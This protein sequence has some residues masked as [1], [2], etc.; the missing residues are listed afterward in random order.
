M[1][2]SASG[3]ISFDTIQTEFGGTNPISLDEYY[4]GGSFVQA[5]ASGTNGVVPSSGAISMSLFFGTAKPPAAGQQAYTAYG[6]YSWV[7]PAG[8]TKVSLVAVGAGGPGNTTQGGGGGGLG[9]K[10]NYTV[11]PG[12][13]YTVSVSSPT[14]GTSFFVS[15][16]TVSGSR[17]CINTAG[18]GGTFVGDGGGNGGGFTAA[19]VYPRG[20]GGAGGYS[21]TGGAGSVTTGNG[22]AGSGGGG[23]GG[24]GQAQGNFTQE[25]VYF[26]GFSGGAGGGGGVG[27]L[28][29]GSNGAGGTI[30]TH[31]SCTVTGSQGGGGGSSGGSGTTGGNTTG[32]TAGNGGAGGAYGGGA[33]L[34]GCFTRYPLPSFSPSTSGNGTNGAAGA[35]AVRIIWPGCARTFPST[36]TANE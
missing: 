16:N 35:G 13:S 11:I 20:G 21:G 25:C 30:G 26:A 8:V 5:G 22:T 19:P 29:Q 17:G 1:A 15:S 14:V 33:G 7:A 34:R 23:G 12:C 28:G 24:G 9:Y 32:F 3:A 27:L 18:Q 4:A 36:R 10:N 31:N 2:I 6:T